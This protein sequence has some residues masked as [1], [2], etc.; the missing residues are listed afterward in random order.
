MRCLTIIKFD[1]SFSQHGYINN[2]IKLLFS[3]ALSKL[4][5]LTLVFLSLERIYKQVST[6]LNKQ[7]KRTNVTWIRPVAL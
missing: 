5:F 6:L 1:R 3:Y 4:G 7:R 2:K